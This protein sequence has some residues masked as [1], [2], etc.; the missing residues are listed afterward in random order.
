M[1]AI[2]IKWDTDGDKEL[3]KELPTEIQIP[4]ELAKDIDMDDY[5][6]E[7]GDYLSDVTGFCHYGFKL[8]D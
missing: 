6:D 2:N 4:D 7:I 8:V 3:L 1:K 5:N